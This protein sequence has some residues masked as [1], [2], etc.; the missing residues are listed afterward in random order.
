MDGVLVLSE[1]LHYRAWFVLAEEF[2]FAMDGFMSF[3][4]SVG[5]SD[6]IVSAGLVRER[7]PSISAQVLLDR[8]RAIFLELLERCGIEAPAG[9][10]EFI[11]LCR[12]N[13][14][15]ALV[16]SSSRRSVDAVLK[17]SGLEGIFDFCV[18]G[19]D[20]KQPK[21]SPEPYLRALDI[22]GAFPD[23]ALAIED[24]P[25]GIASAKAAGLSV[26]VLKT[27]FNDLLRK[28]CGHIMQAGQG[29]DDKTTVSPC[30]AY[31]A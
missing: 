12:A 19:D 8:K 24:S 21:P 7:C 15:L 11:E 2:G 10:A 5:I 31:G 16:S 27:D 29:R 20:I 23:E 6:V 13:R 14:R 18:T 17:A 9:R 3:E 25:N 22:A 30:R 1:P 28:L 4:E 26:L